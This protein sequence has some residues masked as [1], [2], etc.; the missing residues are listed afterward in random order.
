MRDELSWEKWARQVQEYLQALDRLIWPDL[1][2]VGGGVSAAGDYILEPARQT[3]PRY[4]MPG[5]RD[6]VH[7]I[8]ETLGNEVGMLG[9]A[10]LIFE[11]MDTHVPSSERA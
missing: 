10:Y 5:M 1:I 6:H 7:I 2:I 9:A 3:I 11:Y 8:R 4:I